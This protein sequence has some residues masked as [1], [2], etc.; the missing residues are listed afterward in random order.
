[1]I[2]PSDDAVS[3]VALMVLRALFAQDDQTAAV[4][5]LLEAI[6]R[7]L[8][9]GE[10]RHSPEVWATAIPADEFGPLRNADHRRATWA[11]LPEKVTC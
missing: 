5:A 6:L 8:T 7:S 1:V 9:G 2:E 10:R 3:I 11:P 4:A